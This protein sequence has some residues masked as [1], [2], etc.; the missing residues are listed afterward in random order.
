[1]KVDELNHVSYS[2]L[3][4]LPQYTHTTLSDL[5]GAKEYLDKRAKELDHPTEVRVGSCHC[6]A[7]KFAVACKP[8]DKVELCDCSCSICSGVRS[9]LSP[10]FPCGS[11]AETNEKY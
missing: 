8:L 11:V 10:F 3:E 7:I 1:M 6:Q 4:R 5:P 9:S 2:G